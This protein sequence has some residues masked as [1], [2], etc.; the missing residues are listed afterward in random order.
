MLKVQNVELQTKLGFI[1]VTVEGDSFNEVA[2]PEARKIAYNERTKHGMDNAGIESMGGSYPVDVEAEEKAGKG[3]NI[4]AIQPLVDGARTKLANEIT[5]K[6][7]KAVFRQKYK[8]T[9]SL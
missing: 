4:Q 8:I 1:Y 7:K 6:T 5:N 2:S 9:R 3:E